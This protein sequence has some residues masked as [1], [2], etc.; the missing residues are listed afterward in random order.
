MRSIGPVDMSTFSKPKVAFT[1]CDGKGNV[2]G[3]D[4]DVADECFPL[5]LLADLA[6]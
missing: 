4:D 1:C 2:L 5:E 6:C 3:L